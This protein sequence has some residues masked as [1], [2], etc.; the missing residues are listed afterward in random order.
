MKRLFDNAAWCCFS[1]AIALFVLSPALVPQN[2]LLADDPGGTSTGGGGGKCPSN[3]CSTG[4][5]TAG[6]WALGCV[7]IGCGCSAVAPNCDPCY[8]G[9]G[10]VGCECKP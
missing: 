9:A 1:L 6:C 10:F 7:A 8:C 2:R 3:A 5:T 4:C